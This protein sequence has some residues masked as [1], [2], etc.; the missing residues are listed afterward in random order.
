VTSWANI[1]SE[2]CWVCLET[3]RAHANTHAHRRHTTT[4]RH[5]HPFT[6]IEPTLSTQNSSLWGRERSVQF[7]HTTT[8]SHSHS[9]MY[10][11]PNPTSIF[12]KQKNLF[13][14]IQCISRVSWVHH[15]SLSHV[16]APQSRWLKKEQYKRLQEWRKEKGLNS[17][18]AACFPFCLPARQR[19]AVCALWDVM[20]LQQQ[21]A[22]FLLINHIPPHCPC[23]NFLSIHVRSLPFFARCRLAPV[24][25]QGKSLGFQP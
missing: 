9:S 20:D 14:F 22:H 19:A 12:V 2:C 10:I 17:L 16:T 21:I 3:T 25:N 23:V 11:E 5:S 24:L 1:A 4:P 13:H 6:Y 15:Q 18:T 8:H 7:W